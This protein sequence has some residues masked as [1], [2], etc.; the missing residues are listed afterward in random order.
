MADVLSNYKQKALGWQLKVS[1]EFP[2]HYIRQ[3]NALNQEFIVCIEIPWPLLRMWSQLMEGS[4]H[5]F[6]YLDL[7]NLTVT[8]GW[9]TLNRTCQRTINT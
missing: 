8:D 4:S 2:L 7:V 6:N 1:T 3:Q 5:A 9:F